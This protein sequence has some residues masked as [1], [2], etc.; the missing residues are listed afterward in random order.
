MPRPGSG[1][2]DPGW[3]FVHTGILVERF[4]SGDDGYGA[5]YAAGETLTG[6]VDQ[7]EQLVVA[8]T[9]D[10]VI[11]IARVYFPVGTAWIPVQSKVT[12][13]SQF[14]SEVG[15][16]IAANVRDTGTLPLPEFLELALR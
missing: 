14:G 16:V 4:Q 7:G 5:N 9:G 10:E 6:F 8:P 12:L 13:P 3:V 15:E 1:T 2:I 11:S